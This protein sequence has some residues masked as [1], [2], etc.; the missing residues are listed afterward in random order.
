MRSAAEAVSARQS[1]GGS[2]AGN[3][4]L[5]NPEYPAGT[6]VKRHL[7]LYGSS[8]AYTYSG[9]ISGPGVVGVVGTGLTTFTGDNSAHTGNPDS[10]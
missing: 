3:V 4:Y 6:D 10:V 5:A 1:P 9:N 7:A 8:D 2:L